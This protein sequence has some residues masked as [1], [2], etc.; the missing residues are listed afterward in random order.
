MSRSFSCTETP[1]GTFTIVEQA[2]QLK[3]LLFGCCQ[4]SD[5]AFCRTPLLVE[6]EAQLNSYF[7]G[8]LQQFSL[9]I[10]PDGTPFQQCCWA[11]LLRIPYGETCTYGMQAHMIG[12]PKAARAVGMANHR[13]PLPILIPCHRVVG[14]KGQLT[15]YAG[16]LELKKQ[17]LLLEQT[18]QN[19]NP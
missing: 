4:P 9:P 17:L 1:F 13:N 6:A 8:R 18:Y 5:A 12:S 15:G 7:A 16:G 10:A 19:D 11:A 2:G 14:A 3:Q